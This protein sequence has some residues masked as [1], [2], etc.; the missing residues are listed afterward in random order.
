M[1]TVIHISEFLIP[2]CN[3]QGT[4]CKLRRY[5]DSDW[6]DIDGVLHLEGVVGSSTGFFDEV[7]CT[8]ANNTVTVPAFDATPTV[9]ARI[10][11]PRETWQLWDQS[12]SPRNIVFDN[13]FIPSSPTTTTFAALLIANQGQ[14]LTNPPST[15]LNAVG[16]QSL[17]DFTI[18]LW[19]LATS[20]LAGWVRLSTP[21]SDV[22]DPVVVGKNDYATTS[23]SGI[24]KS[25]ITRSPASLVTFVE[26]TD[27]RNTNARIPATDAP[28]RIAYSYAGD[29]SQIVGNI[30]KLNASAGV[31]TVVNTAAGDTGGAV[32]IVTSGSALE[33]SPL[34][35]V[36]AG[37][38]RANFDGQ[39]G[40]T[41]NYYVQIS[42]GVNGACRAVNG[43]PASGQV[44]GRIISYDNPSDTSAFIDFIGP[45]VRAGGSSGQGAVNVLTF[46]ADNTGAT[47]ASAAIRSALDAARAVGAKRVYAPAG[48]YLISQSQI[49]AHSTIFD[50][51]PSIELFGDGVG[52]TIFTVPT[53]AAWNSTTIVSANTGSNQSVHDITFLGTGVAASGSGRVIAATFGAFRPHFYNIE[54]TGFDSLHGITTY[55]PFD[56]QDVSTTLGTTIVAGT[57]TV[58]PVSMNGIYKFRLLTIGGTTENVIV[59]AC[60]ETT[61]TAVF[62]NNHSSAD[63][64]T[65]ISNGAQRAL[66]EN[67]NIHDITG[68]S[69]VVVNSLA[70]TFRNGTIKHVGTSSLHHGF[71]VQGGRNVFDDI[72]IEGVT[73]YSLHQYPAHTGIIDSSGNLYR[74]I[75][76]IDPGVHHV[77]AVS[78]YDD[79]SN[80]TNPYYPAGL[81][82]TRFTT[83]DQCLFK[84]TTARADNFGGLDISGP[85]IFTNNT[86]EDVT[87]FLEPAEGFARAYGNII[88]NIVQSTYFVKIDENYGGGI[89]QFN[90]VPDAR[91]LKGMSA[92]PAANGAGTGFSNSPNTKCGRGLYLAA[93]IGSRYFEAISNVAGVV[94][95]TVQFSGPADDIFLGNTF[96]FT[97]GVDFTLGSDDTAP[98]LALTATHLATAMNNDGQLPRYVFAKAVGAKVYLYLGRMAAGLTISTN[99]SGRIAITSGADGRIF[100][101]HKLIAVVGLGVGNS[102]AGST[103]GTC[104]KKMEVFDAAGASLGFVPIY[105]AIT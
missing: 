59:T 34:I 68:G 32:G 47:D 83:F 44:L 36:A 104:V 41:D 63:T 98:Q 67:F 23:N 69:A 77:E 75:K 11:N 52:K 100:A 45:E 92:Y 6:T 25:S 96:T 94:A 97:S 74:A 105:D 85:V 54:I 30:V 27:S 65:G 7:N 102:A 86:L 35:V 53:N 26:T 72:W 31:P 87:S 84:N 73:G 88:R 101:E 91:I 46:G 17:I 18:G 2:D 22:T 49:T 93:G 5:Y 19:R 38:V 90:Q 13:G 71:Y 37:S 21:A 61:F 70:N 48:I 60:T 62:A 14:T 12:G 57:R 58:T 39:V 16:V 89:E 42:P 82:L 10:G 33:G 64:V 9:T 28:L 24:G 20:V 29:G 51:T 103:P 50:L 81:G 55:L 56:A 15:W 76:S 3:F 78:E 1:P 95:V 80:G 99:Q 79:S 4:T 8:L 66:V 43:Y 40:G